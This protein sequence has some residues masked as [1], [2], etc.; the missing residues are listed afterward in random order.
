MTHRTSTVFLGSPAA[1][2]PSLHALAGHAGIELVGV[3]S[4]PDLP[5]GRRRRLRACP[6]KEAAQ[7]LG[8]PVIGPD[9][10]GGPE[11]M[12]Q[13]RDW[14]V[15][16]A[17]VCA[18]GQIFP[19]R[20]LN[21]PRLGCFNLHFSLLPRWRGASPVQAAILAGDAETGVSLQKMVRELDAG[22]IVASSPPR[23]IR[24]EDSAETLGSVLAEDAARLLEGAI[25]LLTGEQP[26]LA[27]QDTSQATFCRIISKSDGAVD[28][29]AE[30][31]VEIERKCR[32]YTPWPACH[33]FLGGK[34]LVLLEARVETSDPFAG[35]SGGRPPPGVVAE[36]GLVVA[37][38]GTLR[39]LRVK[40]EGKNAMEWDDFQRGNP[41]AVGA[42]L[43]P[44][45]S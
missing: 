30:T 5:A 9:R 18:Y 22:D 43:V 28:F 15:E 41:G 17:V 8:L 6:V 26:P 23:P 19:E 4:Q 20:V 11:A 36:G 38:E 12:A 40:P 10:I 21:L 7:A 2:I 35:G 1:A 29:L 16:L 27:P 13:L 34:R 44:H 39:L 32:A 14:G 42:P 31:A 25:H 3:V 45:A 24:P 37:R 33:A